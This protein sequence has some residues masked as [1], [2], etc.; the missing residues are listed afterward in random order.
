MD[1][2]KTV[3]IIINNYFLVCNKIISLIFLTL[4]IVNNFKTTKI[5]YS[6]K[7][8]NIFDKEINIYVKI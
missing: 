2:K 6:N 3:V 1:V 4:I 5:F 8:I 7:L